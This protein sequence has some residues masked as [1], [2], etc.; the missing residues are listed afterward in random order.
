MTLQS[1]SQMPPENRGSRDLRGLAAARGRYLADKLAAAIALGAK[2]HV[3][4]GAGPE[5][6]AYRNPNPRL[7]LLEADRLAINE[8]SLRSALNNSDFRPDEITFFSWLG[9]TRYLAAQDTIATLAF[10]GSL[11]A[12]TSLVLDYAV[13][14]SPLNSSDQM[15]M[16]G[17]ASR[18]EEPGEPLRL[19][20]NPYALD[21]LLRSAG[22]H[23]IEDLGPREIE[24]LY[25]AKPDGPPMDAGL[26]HFVNARV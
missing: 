26:A 7:R 24:S 25:L 13:D 3:V 10:I 5:P 22:F 2:Q 11:P 23:H 1:P 4:L 6:L 14:R 9:A 18:F 15:A 19:F 12:G 17:L 8:Q 21:R 20:V 16:D